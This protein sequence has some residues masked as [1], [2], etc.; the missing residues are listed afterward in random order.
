VLGVRVFNSSPGVSEMV[1][2]FR[3]P[4]RVSDVK[5]SLVCGRVRQYPDCF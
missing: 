3:L 1:P 5:D 2:V 4:Q